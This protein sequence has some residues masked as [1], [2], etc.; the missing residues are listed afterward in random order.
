MK[1]NFYKNILKYCYFNTFSVFLDSLLMFLKG[2]EIKDR[3]GGKRRVHG[4]V[5]CLYSQYFMHKPR[6]TA[7]GPNC[8]CR[9]WSPLK[10]LILAT[11]K[12]SR[13]CLV[14]IDKKLRY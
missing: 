6:S 4:K 8:S 11:L 7:L 1:T 5:N 10:A 9:G 2:E 3:K 12:C 13:L 14:S